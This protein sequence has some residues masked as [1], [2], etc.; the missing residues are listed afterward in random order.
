MFQSIASYI[1]GAEE[2]FPVPPECTHDDE[3]EVDNDWLLIPVKDKKLNENEEDGNKTLPNRTVNLQESLLLDTS[4]PP[5]L[6]EDEEEEGMESTT[7]DEQDTEEE[8]SEQE[9]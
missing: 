5:C 1:W 2:E 9:E 7:S 4:S 3:I 6:E 8:E